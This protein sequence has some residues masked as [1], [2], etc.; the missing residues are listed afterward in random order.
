VPSRSACTKVSAVGVKALRLRRHSLA[1][2]ADDQR[3]IA[4]PAAAAARATCAT[5]GS[6]AMR[7]ST[8]GL[9]LFMRVPSPAARMMERQLR[10]PAATLPEG[11]NALN[12]E[13]Y[14]GIRLRPERAL[15]AGEAGNLTVEPLHRGFV[16]QTPVTLSIVESGI[17]RRVSYSPAR[18]D[19]GKVPTPPASIGDIGFSGFRVLA[20]TPEQARDVALFQGATFLRAIGQGQVFGAM[21][22]GLSLRTADSRG[23]E[24]PFF[25]AFWIQQP[26][27]D[28][29]LVVHALLDSASVTGVYTY[30][31]RAGEMTIVDTEA[32]L[33]P[34]VAL[35]SFGIA[36]MQ[37]TFLFSLMDRRGIDDYRPQVYEVGG[38][39]MQ[40]GNGE[41]IWRPVSNPKQLQVSVFA[42]NNP[43]GFGFIMRERD[44]NLFQDMDARWEARPTIWMEPIGDWQAGALQLIEIPVGQRNTRQR[45]CRSGG[46][47]NRLQPAASSIFAYRQNWSWWP[48]E[49]PELAT[50]AAT[51]TG[52]ASNSRRRRFVVDFAGERLFSVNMADIVPNRWASN[53]GVQGIRVIPAQESRP[54]RVIFDLD[55]GTE[56]LIELRLVL[57]PVQACQSARLGSIVGPRER[58]FNPT[59]LPSTMRPIRPMPDEQRRLA[60]PAFSHSKNGARTA[61]PTAGQCRLGRIALAGPPL[62]VRRRPCA[63]RLWRLGN[64][65]R[66]QRRQRHHRCSG[67]CWCCS[68]PISS[69]SR[70]PSPALLPASCRCC[71]RRPA[72]LGVPDRLTTRTAVVMPIYNEAPSRVF[73]AMQTMAEGVSADRPRQHFDFFFVSDTTDPDAWIGEERAYFALREKFPTDVKL[74]YRHRAKNTGRKAGNIADFVSRWGGTYEHMLVLD[75]DSLVESGTIVGLAGGDGSRPRQR[76]HPD[77]AAD[78]QPQHPVRPAPAVRGARL[79]PDHRR[80]AQ[81]VDGPRRQLLGPQRHHPHQGLRR[82]LRHAR[83]EGQ[84]AVRRPHHEPRLCR[85]GADPPGRLVGHHGARPRRFL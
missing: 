26:Q 25:R 57:M 10:A 12:L 32:T 8:F 5:I 62:G 37:G 3:E 9:A 78:H 83:T 31:L 11:L 79:W 19:F 23:E 82:P 65:R 81:A 20:G 56:T 69:G 76:H 27:N 50:V 33:F 58:R 43:R 29:T 45:H 14:N 53:S 63:D 36:G 4:G 67:C 18:Y 38:L 61:A 2:A 71:F 72:R 59:R 85:G 52:K 75:A 6:P 68:S 49:R 39:Q 60:M 1:A 35:E 55:T 41:W 44:F 34:R 15:F 77:P 28:G 16:F 17:A 22:R 7:C 80:G 42:A 66:R 48:P 30:T 54:F 64:A 24:F 51:R 40:N 73:A 84:T 21:T 46:R 13:T 70:W 47:R 74:F